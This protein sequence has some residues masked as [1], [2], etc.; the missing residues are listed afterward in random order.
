MEAAYL[1]RLVDGLPP[2]PATVLD[3]GCGAGAPIAEWL[4]AVGCLVTGVDAAPAMLALARARLPAA[5]WIE[6]DMRSLALGAR[7]AAIVAW[8]SFFHLRRAAQRGMFPV[9]RDHLVVGGLLLFT[10]GHADGEAIGQVNG[11]PLYHASLD[12]AA[13]ARLL[14]QHGFDVVLHRDR[15]PAC[16]DHTVW[17]ARAR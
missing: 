17:L 12:P 9:L 6:H 8:D 11:A 1:R 3:L 10:S 16:G 7:F 4:V 5:T 2:G 14:E 13:Y 15:D